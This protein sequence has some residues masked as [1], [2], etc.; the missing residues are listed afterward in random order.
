[1]STKLGRHCIALKHIIIRSLF[2]RSGGA[3]PNSYEIKAAFPNS[4]AIILFPNS[5]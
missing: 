4:L 2:S 1:M 5:W 3:D